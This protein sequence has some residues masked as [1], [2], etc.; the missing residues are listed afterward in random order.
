MDRALDLAWLGS[1]RTRPNPLVGAVVVRD[2][3]VIGDGYHTACGREHA[4][5][6]ALDRA[7]SAARG[8]TLYV[9]LEPCVHHGKTPPCTDRIRESG[10]RRVVVGTLDPD[11]RVSGRGIETLRSYG[12]EVVLGVRAE[13]TLLVNLPY[14]KKALRLGTA[15]TLKMACSLDGRIAKRPGSRDAISGTEARRFTHRLRAIHDGVLVGSETL[16][17]DSPQLDCRLL[18]DVPAPTPVVMDARLRFPAGHRWADERRH[19]IVVAG[20][21][22]DETRRA[23]IADEGGRVLTCARQDGRLDP[24][25]ALESV[26]KAGINSLLV[27]G[28]AEIFSSFAQ[29]GLWDAMHIFVSPVVFGREGVGMASMTIDYDT[30]GAVAVGVSMFDND[31]LIS[32]LRGQTRTSL[33]ER[34]LP[35]VQGE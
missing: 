14:F 33:L 16:L 32:Y 30:L 35:G 19:F 15:V 13:R 1:G 25:S 28:G 24:R 21:D 5:A 31:I 11:P 10:V 4:E 26:G 20:D 2:G 23:R 8:A 18:E 3:L 7:G 34:L 22:C 9:T 12:I 27:E 17:V 29:R 6:E